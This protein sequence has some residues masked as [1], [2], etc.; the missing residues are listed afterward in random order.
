MLL[1]LIFVLRLIRP[2]KSILFFFRDASEGVLQDILPNFLKHSDMFEGFFGV[3]LIIRT[4]RGLLGRM[5]DPP[6]ILP[7]V[8]SPTTP[9]QAVFLSVAIF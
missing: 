9:K 2:G 7:S 3:E 8:R 4:Y 6:F 1:N 5:K